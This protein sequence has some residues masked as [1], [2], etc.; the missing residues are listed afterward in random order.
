MAACTEDAGRHISDGRRPRSLEL[1]A[2]DGDDNNTE[3]FPTLLLSVQSVEIKVYK[4]CRVLITVII[5]YR[6]ILL[7]RD[8][9]F[10][11]KLEPFRWYL[12][13]RAFSTRV[14]VYFNCT[15]P[16]S[17]AI[18]GQSSDACL[19]SKFLHPV[20]TFI[21]VMC[22]CDIISV[23]CVRV[24]CFVLFVQSRLYLSCPVSFVTTF[25]EIGT[26]CV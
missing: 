9:L 11:L 26:W 8:V 17:L 5:V 4:T 12:L 3:T 16:V 1:C 21:R 25:P 15:Q 2:H 13:R 23:L 14:I 6:Y 10:P 20:L 19:K 22:K 7:W 18:H 24:F